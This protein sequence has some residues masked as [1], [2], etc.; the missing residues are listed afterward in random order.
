MQLGRGEEYPRFF[1]AAKEYALE[2]L[3]RAEENL[4]RGADAELIPCPP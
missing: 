2:A 4:T 1:Q 3:G